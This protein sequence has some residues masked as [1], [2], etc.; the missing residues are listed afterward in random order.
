MYFLPSVFAEATKYKTAFSNIRLSLCKFKQKRVSPFPVLIKG[1]ISHSESTTHKY[2]F[3][4][5]A[6]L[7]VYLSR[8]QT[9]PCFKN[10]GQ[11]SACW[12]SAATSLLQIGNVHGICSH[13]HTTVC[14][15]MLDTHMQCITA[16]II[17]TRNNLMFIWGK[18]SVSH[19]ST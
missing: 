8:F 19:I 10:S 15:Q 1:D 18:L 12:Q 14:C 2:R 5:V 7:S 11:T 16:L 13:M 17:R 9:N 6:Q 4:A 3:S